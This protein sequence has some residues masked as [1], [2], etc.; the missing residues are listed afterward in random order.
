MSDRPGP[1]SGG[2]S[3]VVAEVVNILSV[4]NG[5]IKILLLKQWD[6]YKLS[7]QLETDE[8]EVPGGGA[9]IENSNSDRRGGERGPERQN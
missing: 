4:A 3:V 8:E 6:D 5:S 1:I 9:T 2:K 7:I